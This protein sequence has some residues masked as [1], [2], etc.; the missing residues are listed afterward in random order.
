V[1][2]LRAAAARGPAAALVAAAAVAGCGGDASPPQRPSTLAVLQVTV[3]ARGRVS[4]VATAF[5]VGHGRAVTVAHA[6]ADARAVSVAAPGRR[7]TRARVVR[8]NARLDLAVL[9]I[10]A[11]EV[12]ALRVGSP[13]AGQR[14][15]VVVLRGGRPRS[16]RATVRRMI[17]AR[18]REAAGAAVRVRPALELEATVMQG[19]SGAPVLD[20]EGR[21][22]GV[23]FAQSSQGN[24]RAY[25]LDAREIPGAA[26]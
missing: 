8:T 5:A 11:L 19:D 25:A 6:V 15:R 2:A 1:I 7:A 12:D 13:S 23:L 10:G 4:E 17:T 16:L 24:D 22:I 3:P 21:V 20:T 18:V 9:A 14:A 26:R